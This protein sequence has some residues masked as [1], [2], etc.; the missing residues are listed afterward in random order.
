MAR[1][2]KDNSASIGNT[3]LVALERISQG[4]GA[5]IVAKV[6]GRNPAYSVKDRIGTAMIDA[7]EAAGLLVRGS[8]E[9]VVIEPTSGNTG[10]A[11]AFVCAARGYRLILT[12]PETM[13]IERRRMLRAFGAELLLTD[14]AQGMAGAIARATELVAEDPKRYY[15]PQQF[16]NPAN[17]EIHFRT[18][19][20]EIWADTD[21]KVDIFVAG[22]G[23]G[24]TITGV[25]RFFRQ[26]N[27]AVRLV[28]VEPA[29]S[30]VL[31]AIKKGEEPRPGP[32]KIQGLGAGFKPEV[33]DLGLVDE[34]A[35]VENEEAIEMARRLHRDEGLSC[36]ISSGAAV[37]AALRIAKR[38]ENEGKRIVVVLPDAGERYLSSLFDDTAS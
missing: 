5:S 2:Y 28:A 4:T 26:K 35:T 23:T 16:N 10:I 24:G 20:P 7:A 32:H 30:A 29:D 18:T 33:L 8:K 14:G 13:S 27:H 12:M 36:G 21:G 1:I 9:K 17:P 22:V 31:S 25:G 19:G 6:E 15:M 11:L 3:P 38:P 37:V 34:V